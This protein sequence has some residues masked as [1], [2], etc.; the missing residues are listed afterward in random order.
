MGRNGGDAGENCLRAECGRRLPG[1]QA[2]QLGVLLDPG[3]ADEERGFPGVGVLQVVGVVLDP[4]VGVAG[5]APDVFDVLGL[6]AVG[7]GIVGGGEGAAGLEG[8]ALRSIHGLG[9]GGGGGGRAAVHLVLG[10]VHHVVEGGGGV[11]HGPHGV[12]AGCDGLGLQRLQRGGCAH[13]VGQHAAEVIFHINVGDDIVCAVPHGEEE[14]PGIQV[15]RHPALGDLDA[16]LPV[17][18]VAA[19]LESGAHIGGNAAAGEGQGA[20]G[21]IVSHRHLGAGG[22]LLFGLAVHGVAAVYG[23]VQHGG[24]AQGGEPHP[25]HPVP[26]GPGG[27]RRGGGGVR[28][29]GGG[30]KAQRQRE[31]RGQGQEP[32]QCAAPVHGNISFVIS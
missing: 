2:L 31:N 18:G 22:D 5:G 12:S 1:E 16:V 13:F 27:E 20:A 17:G 6:P 11:L 24:G 4:Q 32:F 14:I 19:Q 10:G 7:G 23:E 3:G 29:C 26:G 9:A 30:E 8:D 28:G 21:F 25:H 15:A